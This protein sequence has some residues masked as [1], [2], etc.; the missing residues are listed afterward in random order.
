MGLLQEQ[1]ADISRV[2]K[3][4][5]KVR[6]TGAAADGMVKVTVNANGHLIKTVIDESYL[7]EYEFEELAG[8]MT[9]AAKAAVRKS[10]RRVAEIMAP[11]NDREKSFPALSDIV[12]GAPDLRDL[13]PPGLLPVAARPQRQDADDDGGDESEF[14]TVR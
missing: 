1:M 8:H 9:E 11:I 10:V 2:Q 3:K 7:K 13:M 12:D 14:P 5:A 6:A 4:H